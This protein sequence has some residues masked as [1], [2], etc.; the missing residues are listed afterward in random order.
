MLRSFVNNPALGGFGDESHNDIIIR[1][2]KGKGDDDVDADVNSTA[3]LRN[4]NDDG[5]S[6]DS[7]RGAGRGDAFVQILK[8]L[9]ENAVDACCVASGAAVAVAKGDDNNNDTDIKRVRVNITSE[10]VPVRIEDSTTNFHNNAPPEEKGMTTKMMN[11][12]RIEVIDTGCGMQDIDHC[13]SAFSSNKIDGTASRRRTNNSNNS[14]HLSK[15]EKMRIV[16]MT[17]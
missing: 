4:N 9:V 17:K 1:S 7:F 2:S 16:M 14:H 11:C 15:G 13:V 3:S 5:F 8:E 12:L 10:V 6:E